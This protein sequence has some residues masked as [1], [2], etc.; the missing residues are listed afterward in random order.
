MF[1]WIPGRWRKMN[2][3]SV[4]LTSVASKNVSNQSRNELLVASKNSFKVPMCPQKVAFN[5]KRWQDTNR[6]QLR[7]LL[8]RKPKK[9]LKCTLNRFRFVWDRL[10]GHIATLKLS[11]EATS[12]SFLDWLDA[13]FDA[14][15]V[16]NMPVPFISRHL[17]GIH[18]NI[19][20]E[21]FFSH[22]GQ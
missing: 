13:F 16:R 6:N 15:D 9:L 4:F 21:H 22:I 10:L 20:S 14:T 8:Q 17:P 19:P 5:R 11:F 12:N 3:T 7:V 18:L 2:G 1:R